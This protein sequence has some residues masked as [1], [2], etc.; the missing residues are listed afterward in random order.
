VE[1]VFLGAAAD[2]AGTLDYYMTGSLFARRQS[3]SAGET[4]SD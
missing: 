2:Q 1:T 4:S 3:Q